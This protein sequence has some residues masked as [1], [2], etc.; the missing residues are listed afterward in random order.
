MDR[1]DWMRR[2]CRLYASVRTMKTLVW[3]SRGRHTFSVKYC[4]LCGPYGLRSHRSTLPCN[5]KTATGHVQTKGCGCV[6][7]RHLFWALK[8]E[9]HGISCSLWSLFHRRKLQTLCLAFGLYENQAAG[10]APPAQSAEQVTLDLR[11]VISSSTLG[12][13]AHN[14]AKKQQKNNNKNPTT[15]TGGRSDLTHRL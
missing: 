4:R 13:T 8:F 5:T 10:T 3:Q 14:N 1:F 12:G 7:R 15:K 11:V 2:R 9:F 6:H